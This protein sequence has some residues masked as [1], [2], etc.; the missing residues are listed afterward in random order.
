MTTKDQAI[1]A[2]FKSRAEVLSAEAAAKHLAAPPAAGGVQ[3]PEGY[4]MVPKVPTE[5]MLREAVMNR[6]GPGAYEVLSG[7]G[8]A[9]LEADAASDYRA[10][11][12][13]TPPAAPASDEREAFDGE[14]YV[15][16]WADYWRKRALPAEAALAARAPQAAPQPTAQAPAEQPER[17]L[18]M[19][20]FASS[21]DYHA[22]VRAAERPE[23]AAIKE[24]LT[25][26]PAATP[27]ESS[28]VGAAEPVPAPVQPD[29]LSQRLQRRCVEMGT[30]WRAPD[31]HGVN[32]TTEQATELLRDALGVE[33]EIATPP[34]SVERDAADELERKKAANEWDN[35]N[36]VVPTLKAARDGSWQWYRNMRCKYIVLRID[37]RDLGCIIKDREGERITVSQL[38]RQ[39]PP[40]AADRE[41]RP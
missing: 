26:Q 1:A 5:A 30:Y 39:H 9:A 7:G 20:M 37:M 4:V 15:R 36:D 29:T 31:A 6:A 28:A 19:S 18:S 16:D 33:V 8:L 38:Q 24:S 32:L 35:F 2:M 40:A 12:A 23:A 25:T 3:A 13:A 21:A 34:V 11:L 41:K 10:M 17:R 27:E 22:A 14:Q